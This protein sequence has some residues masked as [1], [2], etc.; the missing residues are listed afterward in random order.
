M[1]PDRKLIGDKGSLQCHPFLFSVVFV[2]KED[3]VVVQHL[4]QVEIDDKPT[5]LRLP[6][7][8]IR[9]PRQT[10]P[11]QGLQ[12]PSPIFSHLIRITLLYAPLTIGRYKES[13]M[14]TPNSTR[15]EVGAYPQVH[16]LEVNSGSRVPPVSTNF[17]NI[18]TTL[19]KGRRPNPKGRLAPG[20]LLYN[21]DKVCLPDLGKHR[22]VK[23]PDERHEALPIGCCQG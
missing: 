10:E 3:V 18:A 12:I 15:I 9:V 6:F 20:V 5:L 17:P 14:R 8:K 21:L 23:Q 7:S 22:V 13:T 16:P 19:G 2:K 4:Y 11:A 1:T